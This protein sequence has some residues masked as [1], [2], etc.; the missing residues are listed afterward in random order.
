MER[1]VRPPP[2]EATRIKRPRRG[3]WCFS[4]VSEN[5][6]LHSLLEEEGCCF[7]CPRLLE[8]GVE[9]PCHRGC[10][11]TPNTPAEVCGGCESTLRSC[12]FS[13]AE[14]WVGSCWFVSEA[15]FLFQGWLRLCSLH[16]GLTGS[17]PGGPRVSP[18]TTPHPTCPSAEWPPACVWQGVLCFSLPENSVPPS[19]WHSVCFH[20]DLEAVPPAAAGESSETALSC[21]LRSL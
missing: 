16:A 18:G 19:R 20:V 9:M 1:F 5:A 15:S 6:M 13:P 21:S 17:S 8:E 7:V 10:V 4:C 2:V 12:A 11:V 14:G 3:T